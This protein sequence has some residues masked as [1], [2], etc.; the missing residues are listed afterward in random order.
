LAPFNFQ[1]LAEPSGSSI[2]VHIRIGKR[3]KTGSE[4]TRRIRS[5]KHGRA[6]ISIIALT[7]YAMKSDRKKFLENGMDGYVT[8][9]VD[10]EELARTIVEVCGVESGEPLS[11][12]V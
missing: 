9:P 6:D 5:G 12:K 11:S 2:K 3:P 1:V 4:A 10:F 7:A 8:K